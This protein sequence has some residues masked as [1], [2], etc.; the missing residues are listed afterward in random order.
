[1][2][3]EYPD[4]P[5]AILQ[6]N[7]VSKEFFADIEVVHFNEQFLND[8]CWDIEEYQLLSMQLGEIIEVF[9]PNNQL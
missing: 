9:Y 6:L 8:L 5:V 7:R 4:N 1:M 3:R 2:F